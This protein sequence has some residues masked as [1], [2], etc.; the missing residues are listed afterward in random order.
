M[1]DLPGNELFDG[2]IDFCDQLLHQLTFYLSLLSSCLALPSR[3]FSKHTRN[4]LVQ[5]YEVVEFLRSDHRD[6]PYPRME[7]MTHI[8]RIQFLL[9]S[10]LHLEPSLLSSFDHITRLGG[11]RHFP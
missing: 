3:A 1:F 11:Q 6:R 8:N 5:S 9:L 7:E 4:P 10:G 2:F